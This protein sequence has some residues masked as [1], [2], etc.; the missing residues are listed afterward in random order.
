MANFQVR[1]LM[2]NVVDERLRAK[3]DGAG[4]CVQDQPTVLTCGQ[5]SPV[6][7]T[8][9]RSDLIERVAV[10]AGEAAKQLEPGQAAQVIEKLAT[11]VGI[12]VLATAS[13]GRGDFYP[14]PNCGGSSYETI[15]TPITPVIS[16]ADV[17]Q[18][19]DLTL[20][21]DRVSQIVKE[22]DRLAAAFEPTGDNRKIVAE[23]LATALETL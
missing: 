11:E 10:L 22:I 16:R 6:M 17:L 15:P 7:H 13:A 14:D 18:F 4:L 20:I 19:S 8:I 23:H 2:V 5:L 21:R 3:V 12:E 9:K 1:D